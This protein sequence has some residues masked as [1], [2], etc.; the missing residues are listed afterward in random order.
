MKNRQQGNFTFVSNKVIMDNRLTAKA[1]GVYVYLQSRQE[2]WQFY[3][4]EIV[5]NFNDGKHSISSAIKELVKFKYLLRIQKRVEGKFSCYE[6]ILNPTESDFIINRKT[7]TRKSDI[8]KSDTNNTDINNTDINN[9]DN[10]GGNKFPNFP[11]GDSENLDD[12]KDQK[13]EKEKPASKRKRFIK[14]SVEEIK[15]YCDE[16]KNDV[17]AEQFFNFYESKG[18][19]VG[20][21]KMKD[22]Q[23]SVRTWEIRN[24][25]SQNNKHKM[26]GA[27]AV[28][29]PNTEFDY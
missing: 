6:W 9:T 25:K 1:K 4:S 21:T 20:R 26:Q 23:A 15:K 16:Q 13:K 17:D 27:N 11:K 19:M 7:E 5:K 28:K 18:W 29:N 12:V 8:G 2:G 24:K 10:I 3:E 14:P 22:W